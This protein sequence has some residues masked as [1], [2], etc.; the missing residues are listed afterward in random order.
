MAADLVQ[1][2]SFEFMS[3]LQMHFKTCPTFARASYDD[4]ATK[5]LLFKDYIKDRRSNRKNLRKT[6]LT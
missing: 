2:L 6:V 4:Q 1:M 3:L 5:S